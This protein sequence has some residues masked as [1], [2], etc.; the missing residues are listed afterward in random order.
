MRSKPLPA[1]PRSTSQAVQRLTLSRLRLRLAMQAPTSN[2]APARAGTGSGP[3]WLDRLSALP[4]VG[5]LVLGLRRWWHRH[6]ARTAA[7]LAA[8]QAKTH[9]QPLARQHPVALLLGGGA[10]GML[11]VASRPWRW[12][13]RPVLVAS[14]LPRLLGLTLRQQPAHGSP[15]FWADLLHVLMTAEPTMARRPAN[16]EWRAD[17]HGDWRAPAPMH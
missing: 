1:D 5:L 15:S 10:A 13:L 16:G 17:Q 6:P 8:D 7:V 3:A 14:L 9:L 11:L 2:A 4:P 12:A